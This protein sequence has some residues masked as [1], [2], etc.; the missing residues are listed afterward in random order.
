MIHGKV[1]TSQKE[2]ELTPQRKEELAAGDG[3]ACPSA[4]AFQLGNAEN[5]KLTE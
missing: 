5:A 2:E 3:A 4:K 1:G